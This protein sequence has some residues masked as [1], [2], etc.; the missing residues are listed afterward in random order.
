[1]SVDGSNAAIAEAVIK[2]LELSGFDPHAM[3][4]ADIAAFFA[5]GLVAMLEGL[6]FRDHE[7][8]VAGARRLLQQ[9]VDQRRRR[10]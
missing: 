5:V 1:M 3:R 6:P 8:A 10:Q 7:R 4:R 9:S 2:A